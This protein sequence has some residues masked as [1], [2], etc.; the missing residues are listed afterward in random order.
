M[1][2][3]FAKT[4]LF[5]AKRIDFLKIRYKI[6]QYVNSVHACKPKFGLYLRLSFS[7]A[8]LHSL[9][10]ALYIISYTERSILALLSA[11]REYLVTFKLTSQVV[12]SARPLT[13][14]LSLVRAQRVK[15]KEMITFKSRVQS[16]VTR[17]QAL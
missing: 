10:F 15:R 5:F 6:V 14:R 11:Y 13:T 7:S 12:Q 2:L 9:P 4:L 3:S 8:L 17:A 16:F 1:D